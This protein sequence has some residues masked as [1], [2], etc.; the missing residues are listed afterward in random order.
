MPAGKIGE[1]C[2][3]QV[4]VSQTAGPWG[5]QTKVQLQ[6]NE[7]G[8]ATW[9]DTALERPCPG[10]QAQVGLEVAGAAEALVTHLMGMGTG[11]S[12][13]C[14]VHPGSLLPPPHL[15]ATPPPPP[16]CD[17]GLEAFPHDSSLGPRYLAHWSQAD[18]VSTLVLLPA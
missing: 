18:W 2:Q 8:E 16:P 4:G 13:A 15:E 7:L 11:I 5:M 14:L 9:A 1:R 17:A 12:S 6:M 10:V 3:G